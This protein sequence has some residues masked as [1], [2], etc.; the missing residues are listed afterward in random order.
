MHEQIV[1]RQELQKHAD[2]CIAKL[3]AKID[4]SAEFDG[5][6]AEHESLRSSQMNYALAL[7]YDA[8]ETI[9]AFSRGPGLG[10]RKKKKKKGGAKPRKNNV[11]QLVKEIMEI[12]DL[13]EGKP[14]LTTLQQIT[15]DPYEQATETFIDRE[16]DPTLMIEEEDYGDETSL[17]LQ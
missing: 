2:Q 4:T 16:R 9:S 12:N 8:A 14:Q 15:E 3:Q 1:M 10:K 7:G 6:I 13:E 17:L 11:Q 5:E